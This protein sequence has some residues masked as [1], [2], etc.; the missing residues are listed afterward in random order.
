MWERVI[1]IISHILSLVAFGF[2]CYAF[3]TPTWFQGK[4]P[5]HAGDVTI[6]LWYVCQVG[7]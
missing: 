5:H 4:S 6:G 3:A 7:S 2:F 1:P